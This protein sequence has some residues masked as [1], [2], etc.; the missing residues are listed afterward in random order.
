MT[1]NPSAV[2]LYRQPSSQEQWWQIIEYL[3][4]SS[5]W[6]PFLPFLSIP[7]QLPC[8]CLTVFQRGGGHLRGGGPCPSAVAGLHHDSILGE[9]LQVVKHQALCIVPRGLHADHTELVVSPRAVLPVAHLVASDGSVLEV[10]LR[11]LMME[12]HT[13]FWRQCGLNVPALVPIITR[14]REIGIKSLM[15]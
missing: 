7:S 5:I 6:L 3:Y 13:F 2:I 15:R 11:R 14:V 1:P 12:K 8:S 9:L 4:I 10:L